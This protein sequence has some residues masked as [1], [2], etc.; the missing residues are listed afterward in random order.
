MFCILCILEDT[1]ER[2]LLRATGKIVAGGFQDQTNW[3]GIEGH[4][5]ELSLTGNCNLTLVKSKRR[6]TRTHYRKM[7][8]ALISALT[9]CQTGSAHWRLFQ[10]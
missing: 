8:A 6:S 9:F 10:H 3:P 5:A 2:S 1:P 7:L 4:I